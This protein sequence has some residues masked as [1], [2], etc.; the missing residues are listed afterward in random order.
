MSIFSLCLDSQSCEYKM[1]L[2]ASSDDMI[3]LSSK[4]CICTNAEVLIRVINCTTWCYMLT[5]F[6]MGKA[7]NFT[8]FFAVMAVSNSGNTWAR[9]WGKYVSLSIFPWWINTCLGWPNRKQGVSMPGDWGSLILLYTSH[10]AGAAW[11][12]LVLTRQRT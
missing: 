12:L 7:C 8:F 1:S 9:F 4:V 6:Y 5:I 2:R 10:P 11:M 3:W